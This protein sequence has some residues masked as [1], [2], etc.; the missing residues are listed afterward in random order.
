MKRD[1]RP[2]TPELWPALEDLFGSRGACNGCCA[3][4]FAR[5]KAKSRQHAV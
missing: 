2:M 5:A 4:Y 3:M 1:V